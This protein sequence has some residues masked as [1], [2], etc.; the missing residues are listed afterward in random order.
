MHGS[1][2]LAWRDTKVPPPT[3]GQVDQYKRREAALNVDIAKLGML[4][5]GSTLQSKLAAAIGA[6]LADMREGDFGEED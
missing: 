6:R 4:E 1:N 5:R 3:P 2:S